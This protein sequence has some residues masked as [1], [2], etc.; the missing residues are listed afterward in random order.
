MMGFT[1]VSVGSARLLI[2]DGYEGM[3][4]VLVDAWEGRAEEWIEGGRAPHPVVVL[5]DGGKAV[6]RR[7]MRGGMV[8]HVNRD[9]YFGGDRAAH[10]L[11]A[12]EVA[13]AG[14]VHAP[15]VIAAGRIAAFPG[16]RAMIA[17]RLIPGVKDAATAL[18]GGRDLNEVLFEAGQQIGRMHA[19][20]VGHP[21]LNLR[22][23][24]VGK[25]G[26]L[27]IIDFDRALVVEGVVPRARRQRDLSRLVRSFAKLGMPLSEVRRGG[28]E[29]GYLSER[30]DLE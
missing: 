17:T 2:R 13:R 28:L 9:R 21:D 18:L 26:E 16:Y 24:L 19:A 6:V 1:R 12:T 14:G 30:P 23:L 15:E 11:R 8:R 20:G 27:W 5:P 25:L 29:V 10:E 4:G 7:Y 22:N 3:A